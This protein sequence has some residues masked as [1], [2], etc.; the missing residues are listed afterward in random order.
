V[1]D[2]KADVHIED[3]WRIYLLKENIDFIKETK[4]DV[5]R[6]DGGKMS[7]I[8]IPSAFSS[9]PEDIHTV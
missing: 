3:L 2:E 9:L 6:C 1:A 8:S 7:N 4:W 5:L